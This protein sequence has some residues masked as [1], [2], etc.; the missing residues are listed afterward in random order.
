MEND[1]NE[2]QTKRICKKCLLKEFDYDK[3]QKDLL[4]AIEILDKDVKA[5]NELYDNRLNI[6]KQCERLFEGTCKACGCYVE[7]RAAV[8]K[9]RCPYK[10][11]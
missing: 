7:L 9:S 4:K 1:N 5:D 11:W 2:K 10:L 6:C 3:Y 8:K